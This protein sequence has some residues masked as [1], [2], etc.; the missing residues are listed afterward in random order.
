MQV[1]TL[2]EAGSYEDALSLCA[3]CKVWI[4]VGLCPV[5]VGNGDATSAAV[6]IA[7][8]RRDNGKGRDRMPFVRC[9]VAWL[10]TVVQ[11]TDSSS[12]SATFDTL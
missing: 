5:V 2:A 12:R 6:D 11:W 4:C 3:M 9:D 10:T 7:P 8:A 1:E